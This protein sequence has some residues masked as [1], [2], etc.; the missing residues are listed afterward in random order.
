MLAE[1]FQMI[2][3]LSNSVLVSFASEFRDFDGKLENAVKYIKPSIMIKPS[4][5]AFEP[6]RIVFQH[7]SFCHYCPLC[8]AN[9][10][11]CLT[12]NLFLWIH[13]P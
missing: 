13:L 2:I 5:S 10:D 4:P 1:R 8:Q 3:E 11:H 7:Q 12:E 9:F 6:P